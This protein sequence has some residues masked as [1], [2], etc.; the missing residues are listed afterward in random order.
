MSSTQGTAAAHHDDGCLAGCGTALITPFTASGSIDERA[1]RG[2]VDWQINEGIDFV[3][4]CGSTGE[5]ATM[6]R[7]GH[8]L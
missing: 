7:D 3:V 5:A 4:P 6:L 2:F 1:L 8:R